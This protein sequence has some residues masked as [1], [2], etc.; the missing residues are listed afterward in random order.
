MDIVKA[1]LDAGADANVRD[2]RGSTPLHM[3]TYGKNPNPAVLKLLVHAGAYVN[4]RDK[5][6]QTPLHKAVFL[7]K[8]LRIVKALLDL[9]ADVNAK[10]NLGWT[11]L[12][13]AQIGGD[14]ALVEL[15]KERGGVCPTRLP[16][17]GGP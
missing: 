3:A 17:S 7:G 16:R 9:G 10:D 5:H 13:Y 2:N 14:K 8:D 1:L 11:P 4:A 15:L 12:C 6:G